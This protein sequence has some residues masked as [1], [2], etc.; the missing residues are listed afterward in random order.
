MLEVRPAGAVLLSRGRSKTVIVTVVL[1]CLT[2][3]NP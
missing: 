2:V 3:P 1:E